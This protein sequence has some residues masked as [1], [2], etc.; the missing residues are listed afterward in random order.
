MSLARLGT[1]KPAAAPPVELAAV[2]RAATDRAHQELELSLDLLGREPDR[3]RFRRV[4]E[5]FYGFHAVW[6][7]AIR[8]REELRAFQEPRTRLPH[9][10]RDLAALGLPTAKLVDLPRCA[11][12]RD[13]ANGLP[14]AIGSIYVMEGSTLGG[15]VIARA[16]S[17]LDWVPPG[18][19]AYFQPYGDRTGAM[20]RA[21]RAWADEMVPPQDH[22]LA[23]AG[24][25]RTF[26]LLREWL[27]P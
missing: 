17:G 20:W 14:Q 3:Q 8:E 23:A 19:L 24:A 16:L 9:L 26:A 27:T 10:E 15:Q 5:R 1:R 2:L 7:Q 12:A 18:G 13:L 11:A 25:Q 4:L 21:F 22:A 6:E